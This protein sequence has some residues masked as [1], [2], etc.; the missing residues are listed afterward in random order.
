MNKN[1]ACVCRINP[2][3]LPPEPLWE[4]AKK[5]IPPWPEKP[6]GGRPPMPD[7][8]A[9]DAIFYISRTGIQW[10]ALPRCLGAAS[11]VHDRFQKW[12][13]EGV[14]QNLWR[15]GLLKYDEL[16]SLDWQWQTLDGAMTK[17]P[18]GQEK[19]GPNPTDRAKSGTKRHLLTEGNGIPTALV[20]TGAQRHDK[21]QVRNVL[22]RIIVE[23]PQPTQRKPQHLAADRGY[24]YPDVR[25]LLA[26]YGYTAHIKSRGE[27]IKAKENIPGYR[28]RRWVNERTHSWMNRFRRI[29]TRWEKK[30]DNYE[31]ILHLA[32]AY[33]TFKQAGVF[34]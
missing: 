34:G 9:F 1:H 22:E 4:C 20:V 28:A 24:D 17:A 15:A 6:N 31:A 26:A 12:C 13:V 27:E 10:N 23:R 32:C 30:S 7:K 5:I 8:K 33:I 16:K 11:T 21:T 14:F 29:L 19:T 3:F 2:E 25:E 18:L